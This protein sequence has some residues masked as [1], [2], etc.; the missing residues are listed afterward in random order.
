MGRGWGAIGARFVGKTFSKKF[1]PTPLS[2]TPKKGNRTIAG[3]SGCR[4]VGRH[5]LWGDPQ[6]GAEAVAASSADIIPQRDKYCNGKT[7]IFNRD[8]MR[9]CSR[10]GFRSNAA[11]IPVKFCT[12]PGVGAVFPAGAEGGRREEVCRCAPQQ[13]S[14]AG[15][16]GAMESSDRS[17]AFPGIIVTSPSGTS[18]RGRT[19]R[20]HPKAA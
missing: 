2:K 17:E 13:E 11:K 18:N 6:G 9:V 16:P 4:T 7:K 12:D 19:G 20:V 1:S 3:G 5:H 14:R 15:N 10:Y 8:V